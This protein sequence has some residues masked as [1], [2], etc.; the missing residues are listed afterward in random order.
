MG[1][2]SAFPALAGV[3]LV[4]VGLTDHMAPSEMWFTVSCL[5]PVQMRGADVFAKES[6]GMCFLDLHLMECKTACITILYG[7]VW[8]WEKYVY[9]RLNADS[10]PHHRNPPRGA[11]PQRAVVLSRQI[12]ARKRDGEKD[13]GRQRG[14]K[15]GVIYNKDLLSWGDWTSPDSL[16]KAVWEWMWNEMCSATT[17]ERTLCKERT[18]KVPN[19][20]V[21]KCYIVPI[22]T[23]VSGGA[24]FHD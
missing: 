5:R 11:P 21:W 9:E 15:R 14:R 23:L 8:D 7:S 13:K 17:P 20:A 24:A 3:P 22:F 10:E 6:K 12:Q 16:S 19:T 18:V 2:D 4:R 1:V